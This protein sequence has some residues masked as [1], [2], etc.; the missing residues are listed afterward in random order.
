MA[1]MSGNR[2]VTFAQAP[3]ATHDC[4]EIELV[5][6]ASDSMVATIPQP[7]CGPLRFVLLGPAQHYTLPGITQHDQLFRIPFA[8]ENAGTGTFNGSLAMPLDSAAPVQRGRQLDARYSRGFLGEFRRIG[9]TMSGLRPGERTRGDTLIFAVDPLTQGLRLWLTTES[10]RP[11]RPIPVQESR[12]PRDE[13]PPGR[14]IEQFVSRSGL[15]KVRE[16]RVI[17]RLR[18]PELAIFTTSYGEP[19]DCPA[20]CFYFGVTGLAYHG[21]IGWLRSDTAVHSP[22]PLAA[23]ETFLFS[24]A[25]HDTI[26]AR[27]GPYNQVDNLIAP[28]LLQQPQVPRPLLMRYVERVYADIDDR[29]ASLLAN[30]PA[31]EREPDILTIVANMPGPLYRASETATRKLDK[32]AA[33]LV[34]DPTTS[35]RTLWVLANVIRADDDSATA[36]AIARHPNGRANPAVLSRVAVNHPWVR[37][38]LVASLHVSERVRRMVAALLESHEPAPLAQ[39]LLDD[40]E[41][42]KSLD[43]LLVLANRFAN[44]AATRR[45]PEG[46]LRWLERDYVLIR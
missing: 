2:S 37:P 22:F 39:R 3:S 11:K 46:S 27:L 33:V 44:N 32:L 10:A 38:E 6:P 19:Q 20:G 26:M 24:V 13:G 5:L 21:K 28:L 17:L 45:L 9:G 40:P 12:A 1:A 8:L 41:A 31:V 18:R 35:A 23:T 4:F 14:V 42:G 34:H 43:V 15:P 30:S 7:F 25:F 29:I 36:A 16:T